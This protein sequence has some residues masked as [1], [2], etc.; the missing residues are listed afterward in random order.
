MPTIIFLNKRVG[1]FLPKRLCSK[2]FGRYFNFSP[3][4]SFRVEITKQ[5]VLLISNFGEA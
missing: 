1:I 2:G 3:A 5:Q 4:V